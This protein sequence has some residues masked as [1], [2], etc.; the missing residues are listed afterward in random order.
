MMRGEVKAWNPYHGWVPVYF[1][2][3]EEGEA[4]SSR[5]CGQAIPELEGLLP[6]LQ[7]SNSTFAISFPKKYELQLLEQLK[8]L[9][10]P[11]LQIQ[12]TRV[13]GIIQTVKTIILNWTLQLEE[14]GILGEGLTFSSKEQEKVTTSAASHVTNFYGPVG[15]SQIQQQS[16]N[17]IQITAG[18][19]VIVTDAIYIEQV[20]ALVPKVKDAI[21]KLGLGKAQVDE[22]NSELDTVEAQ[23]RSPKP[24]RA[25]IK[26]SFET[27]Q[28]I[29]EAA[30]GGAAAQLIYEIGKFLAGG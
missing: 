28:R 16:P 15:Q 26:S 14:D 2:S 4:Y 8:P 29:L 13:L 18:D 23:V 24:K 10:R 11:T 30:A 9:T 3:A 1:Q 22:V 5:A 25:I 17:A 12:P 20:K 7:H 19:D 21:E 27:I 6:S